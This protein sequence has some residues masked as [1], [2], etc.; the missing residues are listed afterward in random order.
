MQW[1]GVGRTVRAGPSCFSSAAVR[2]LSASSATAL[3]VA[4]AAAPSSSSP[5]FRDDKCYFEG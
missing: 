4:A 1:A 2:P 3:A 5:E